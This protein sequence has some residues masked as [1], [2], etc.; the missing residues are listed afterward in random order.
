MMDDQHGAPATCEGLDATTTVRQL[1]DAVAAFRDARGWARF[2]SPKNLS[3]AIAIE[4]AELME[5]FQWVDVAESRALLEQ[6]AP[7][8][9]AGAELADV[10]I[11]CLSLAS[12]A[13]YDV[14]TI[15]SDKLAVSERKYPVDRYRGRF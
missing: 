5:C 12:A 14:T 10:L 6:P 1:V 2:H 7:R 11:Y 8:A 15:I 3:M 4:A 9:A 13:G